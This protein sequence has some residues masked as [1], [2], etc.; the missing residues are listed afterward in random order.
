MRLSWS[1]EKTRT[2]TAMLIYVSGCAYGV[3][4]VSEEGEQARWGG[5]GG[6]DK[7]TGHK[8]AA[9]EQQ[10]DAAGRGCKGMPEQAAPLR[11][12]MEVP[13]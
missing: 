10:H 13:H 7:Q 6:M 8:V 11:Q 9:A 2:K 3:L 5:G 12:V 1:G 4:D